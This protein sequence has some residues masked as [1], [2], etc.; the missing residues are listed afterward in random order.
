[1]LTVE[2]FFPKKKKIKLPVR[3]Q[4][5]LFGKKLKSNF[6]IKRR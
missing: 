3:K 4:Q 5:T 1:M 6:R 2:I